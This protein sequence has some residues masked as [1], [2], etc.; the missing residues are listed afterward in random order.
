MPPEQLRLVEVWTPQDRLKICGSA[1]AG[2]LSPVSYEE[3]HPWI[4]LVEQ[5]LQ[6]WGWGA[7]P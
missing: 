4:S 2:P 7:S 5:R 6:G 3:V 1:A